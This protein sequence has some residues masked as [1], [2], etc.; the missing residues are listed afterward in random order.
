MLKQTFSFFTK[1][2]GLVAI[3]AFSFAFA[4]PVQAEEM[5]NGYYITD[6]ESS[7]EDAETDLSNAIINQGLVIDYTGHVG[8]MLTRTSDAVGMNS[9]YKNAIY[10]QFC[11]SKHTHEA[12]A[13][14]PRNIA[15]CPYVVFIYEMADGSGLKIG[16]RRP[17]GVEGAASAEALA[18]VDELL[19][20]IV[21]EAAEGF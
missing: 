7:F 11:S 19:K 4:L 6:S 5:G 8:N 2:V 14:D 16:Y 21:S 12:V 17:I 1:S 13:A 10:M 15:I 20:S 9:P 18:G 3:L